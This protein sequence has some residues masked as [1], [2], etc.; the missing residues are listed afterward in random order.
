MIL[1]VGWFGGGLLVRDRRRST[2]DSRSGGVAGVSGGLAGGRAPLGPDPRSQFV[3]FALSFFLLSTGGH[4]LHLF[5]KAMKS[6]FCLFVTLDP[7]T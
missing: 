7:G 3:P 1:W 2:A 5:M 6:S 4:S